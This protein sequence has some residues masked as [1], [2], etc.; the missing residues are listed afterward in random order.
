MTLTVDLA[1]ELV[2]ALRAMAQR[3]GVD[4]D[5]YIARALQEHVRCY[6]NAPNHLPAEEAVLLKQINEGLPEQTWKRYH[7]L[8]AKRRAARLTPTEHQELMAL[9][10]EVELWNARRIEIVAELARCR[11]LSLAEMMGQLGLTQ[12]SDA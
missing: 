4:A 5:D 3:A 2:N 1:P 12:P 8:V 11:G 7:D 6:Q 10:N 9:T